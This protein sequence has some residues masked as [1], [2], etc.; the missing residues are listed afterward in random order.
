[1]DKRGSVRIE[2]SRTK[3]VDRLTYKN[4]VWPLSS[5][6]HQSN[7]NSKINYFREKLQGEK[8]KVAKKP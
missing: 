8:V 2:K 4:M 5:Y 1:V 6:E 3:Y 7:A